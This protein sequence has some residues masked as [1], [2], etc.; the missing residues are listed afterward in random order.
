MKFKIDENLPVEIAELL[1]LAHHDAVT[2]TNQ[3]LNG[4]DNLDIIE[5]CIQEGRVLVTSDLDFADIRAYPPHQFPGIMVFRVRRQDKRV[6]IATFQQVIPMIEREPVEHHLWIIE[7]TRV[8]IRGEEE[9]G[10]LHGKR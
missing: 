10:D 2:V 3:G 8:R 9:G 7:E 1:Q 4:E 5:V 6:F